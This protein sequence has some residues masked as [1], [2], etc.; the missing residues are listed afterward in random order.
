MSSQCTAEAL[1]AQRRNSCGTKLREGED[2][3]ID[4]F[5]AM[6]AA[7]DAMDTAFAE[8]RETSF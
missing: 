8:D 4:A 3:E 2:P 7:I 5:E 1:R 6:K